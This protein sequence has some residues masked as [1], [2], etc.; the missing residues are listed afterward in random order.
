M[1]IIL[2][3]EI[4]RT[5]NYWHE[6]QW[7]TGRNLAIKQSLL[8]ILSRSSNFKIKQMFLK[9]DKKNRTEKKTE[10]INASYEKCY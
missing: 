3:S 9:A 7:K 2:L 5:E 6:L 10:F 4:T 8:S 1:G